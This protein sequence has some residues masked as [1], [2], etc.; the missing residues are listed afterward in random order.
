MT[1][2][3]NVFVYENWSGPVPNKIGELYID[4][5]KGKEVISFEYDEEWLVKADRNFVFDP[6]LSLFRGRQYTPLIK[7]MFGVFADSCPDRWGRL[8]MKRREAILAR[9]EDRKPRHL[10]EIDFLLGV[11]DETRMGALRFAKSE[12]GPFVADDRGLAAPPWTTLRR[13]ESASLAFEKN[14]DAMEEK[15]IQ[16]LIVPGSS[17]GGARPKA[18]VVAPDNSLWIAK[19]PS[20]QD[21]VNV[22]AWEMVVHELAALCGINVPYAKLENF[23]K[24]GSTFLTRRFDRDGEKRIHFASA[25]TLLGKI[26]GAGVQDG[27]SYL[28]IA[29]LIR[30]YGATPRKDLL[31]LWKRMVFNMAVSNTDDHLRN[32]GFIFSN[33]GWTLSPAYDVNPNAEGDALSLDV[34][35]HSRAI[36]FGLA[37]SVARLFDITEK[38]ASELQNEIKDVVDNHWRRLAKKFELSRGEIE[39]MAPAFNMAFKS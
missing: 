30:K 7:S 11:H 20:K 4:A 37:L 9:I 29:S 6:D 27:S 1:S 21:D 14:D 39:D 15:W 24:V 31:E 38:Q 5:G 2:L 32:H 17:L 33:E 19:F 28:D 8:L 3:D 22:G 34:D 13:L 26:D 36:D 16:Q 25:M 12:N 18:S 35:E 10:A 23:S